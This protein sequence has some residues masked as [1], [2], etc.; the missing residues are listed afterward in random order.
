MMML[1]NNEYK[2]IYL[3]TNAIIAIVDNENGCRKGFFEKF[4][5]EG[6]KY[7]PCFGF[8]NLCEIR[9][10]KDMYQRVLD[11]FSVM[12]CLMLYHYRILVKEEFEAYKQG[13]P[14]ILNNEV[15]RA[16][17]PMGQNSSENMRLFIDTLENTIKELLENE[18]KELGEVV[19]TW[20]EKRES[21]I[22]MLNTYDF[23]DKQ[24][25]E[26]FLDHELESIKHNLDYEKIYVQ[27]DKL[28]SFFPSQR[29]IEYSLYRRQYFTKKRLKLNDVMDI[30]M[31]AYYPYVDAV[32]T[33][34]FQADVCKKAKNHIPQMKDL[35]VYTLRDIKS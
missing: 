8:V 31:S 30:R 27:D 21:N 20:E 11:F 35:E 2:L 16:F 10:K 29:I 12:P 3:D 33:E 25:E 26:I 1:N 34:G 13:Q 24:L 18:K 17:T 28:F 15:M 23:N 14:M 9:P 19:Q 5:S 7:I 4:F 32:I 6:A 22:K